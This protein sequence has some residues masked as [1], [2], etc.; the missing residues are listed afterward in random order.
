MA[1]EIGRIVKIHGREFL[2]VSKIGLETGDYLYLM[3]IKKPIS[4]IIA[5][6]VYLRK[7]IVEINIVNDKIE[8]EKLYKKFVESLS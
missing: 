6:A 7:N 4:S 8:R 2:V 3:S 5:K 1:K